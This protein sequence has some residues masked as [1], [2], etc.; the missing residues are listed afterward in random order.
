MAEF[1]QYQY[2]FDLVACLL[3]TGNKKAFTSLFVPGTEMMQ[4][5][6]KIVQF[7]AEMTQFRT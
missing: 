3:E 1:S 7:K 4:Y 2:I 5:R 6:A